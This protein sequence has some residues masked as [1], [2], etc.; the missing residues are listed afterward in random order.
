MY[1]VL[2]LAVQIHHKFMMEMNEEI[3][4]VNNQTNCWLNVGPM[5]GPTFSQY[6]M[7]AV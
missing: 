7:F 2:Y 3:V 5:I 4:N 1:N 6:L